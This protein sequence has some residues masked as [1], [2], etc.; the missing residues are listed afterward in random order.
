MAEQVRRSAQIERQENGLFPARGVARQ[1][2]ALLTGH[3]AELRAEGYV[4]S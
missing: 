2:W 4:E 1:S 3:K